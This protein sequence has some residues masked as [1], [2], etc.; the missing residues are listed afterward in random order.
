MMKPPPAPINPLNA[1]VRT[2]KRRTIISE[3]LS[4]D[5]VFLDVNDLIAT[6]K[7]TSINNIEIAVSNERAKSPTIKLPGKLGMIDF[8]IKNATNILGNTKIRPCLKSMFPVFIFR[9]T[10]TP[11]A[12]V[13]IKSEYVVANIIDVP[14][15]TLTN[16]TVRIDPPPPTRPRTIPIKTDIIKPIMYKLILCYF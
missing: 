16:G 8:R 2:P 10:P 11:E 14:K 9:T 4:L 12:A 7:I 13:T 1:P 3:V 6:N 5:T 15:K